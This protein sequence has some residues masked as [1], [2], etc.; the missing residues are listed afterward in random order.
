M[1]LSASNDLPQY[2]LQ[3][4]SGDAA[5][6]FHDTAGW[7]NL[8]TSMKCLEHMI[9]GTGH[10]FLPFI[11]QVWRER[12]KLNCSLFPFALSDLLLHLLPNPQDLLD[13]IFQALTHTNRFVRETGFSVCGALVSCGAEG[14]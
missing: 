14:E 12:E 11:N 13:L 10:K 6:I 7:R 2:C 8:E 5:Q 3:R 4:N 9:I 1:W